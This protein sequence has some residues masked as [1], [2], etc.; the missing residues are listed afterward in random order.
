M[1]ALKHMCICAMRT[2]RSHAFMVEIFK[3]KT[4]MQL[5]VE[6]GRKKVDH[7]KRDASFIFESKKAVKE[8]YATWRQLMLQQMHQHYK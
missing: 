7:D 8:P 2:I 6:K 3:N 1:S 4:Q 5:Y